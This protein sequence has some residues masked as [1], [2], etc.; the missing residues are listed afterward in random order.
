MSL[1]GGTD[2]RSVTAWETLYSPRLEDP[3]QREYFSSSR[4]PFE[5]GC[6]F[7]DKVFGS[8]LATAWARYCPALSTGE[9]LAD[10]SVVL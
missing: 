6:E 3:A 8:F 2:S 1:K 10:G 5:T 9:Q 4:T 7:Y